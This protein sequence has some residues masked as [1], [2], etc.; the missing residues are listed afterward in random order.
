MLSTILVGT[1]ILIIGVSF[2]ILLRKFIRN[3]PDQKLEA[4]KCRV[5]IAGS[6][7]TITAIL[8]GG[9]WALNNYYVSR[10]GIPAFEINHEIQH[11]KTVD[12]EYLLRV[13][14]NV[15]NIGKGRLVLKAEN[16]YINYHN[17]RS[18]NINA[19]KPKLGPINFNK[20]SGD[21]KYFDSLKSADTGKNVELEPNESEA[22]VFHHLIPGDVTDIS[23][24]IK[25]GEEIPGK[26][27][28]YKIE[29]Q[30]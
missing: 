7:T 18:N 3:I 13:W 8:I 23:L 1:L 24:F 19:E 25:L 15:K 28:L 2:L 22:I 12:N 29:P 30:N 10:V 21:G 20:Y 6:I 14:V 9:L 17:L 5:N 16:V 27:I 11:V 26:W 4:T